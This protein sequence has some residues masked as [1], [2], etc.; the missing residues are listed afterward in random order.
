MIVQSVIVVLSLGYLGLVG[1]HLL[2]RRKTAAR[3]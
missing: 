2:A 1:Q 3:A